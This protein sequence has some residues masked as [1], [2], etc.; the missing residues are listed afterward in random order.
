MVHVSQHVAAKG[1]AASSALR[2]STVLALFHPALPRTRALLLVWAYRVAVLVADLI[3]RRAAYPLLDLA[4]DLFWL[5]NHRARRAVEANLL[6]VM[7]RPGKRWRQ[8]VRAAFRHGARNYYDT[9]RIP[10]MTAEQINKLV[11]TSGWDHVRTALEGGRGV[12]IVGPHVG[13]VALGGQAFAAQGF[14]VRVVVERVDP[15][16]LLRLLMRLRK[17]VGVHRIPV[18]PRVT[19][20]LLAALRRN[21][22]V[23]LIVD[24]DVGS[25]AMRAVEVPFFGR[26]ARLPAGPAVLSLRSGAPILSG[27]NVRQRDERFAG[28]IEPPI[29]VTTS[30]DTRQDVQQL[31][32]AIAS[33]LEYHIGRHPEQWTVFQPVWRARSGDR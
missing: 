23:V 12:I 7:G 8:A 17:G 9:F 18:G 29:S 19:S 14:T 20:E 26:P 16:E 2:A 10:G 22:V 27:V 1:L 11:P 33:R 15:P 32:R 28:V 4:G 31:T 25:P 3:P 13:S 6:Q 5:L 21:E 30:G 24:R